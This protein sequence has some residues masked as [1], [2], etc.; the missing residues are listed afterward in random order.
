MI[1]IGGFLLLVQAFVSS[2]TTTKVLV[3]V[4]SLVALTF[5]WFYATGGEDDLDEDA[6][7]SLPTWHVLAVAPFFHSRFDFL[8]AA[9]K[10]SGQAIFKFNL[11]RVRHHLVLPITITSA[12]PRVF[13]TQSLL[14]LGQ[15]VAGTF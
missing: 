9:F 1:F 7:P 13:R 8:N 6:P 11:F 15:K 4:P 10:T 12:D 3:A 2:P 14:C 5:L